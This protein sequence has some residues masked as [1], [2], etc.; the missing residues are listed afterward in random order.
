[1]FKKIVS[2]L[3]FSPALVGQLSFYAKRL[4]K[5]EISRRLGLIF[6]IFTLVIQ[7]LAVFQPPE[8]ANASSQYDM[9]QGG[10][11]SINDFLD[12][13]DN[14]T[15]NLQDIMEYVGITRKEITAATYTTFTV[16]S[17]IKYNWS[18]ASRVSYQD[19]ERQYIIPST[20]GTQT[21]TVYSRPLDLS[22]ASGTTLYAWIGSSA[23]MGKFAILQSCGNLETVKLPTIPAPT[24]KTTTTTTTTNDEEEE[25]ED[26]EEPKRCAVK[27]SL[28]ASDN[29]CTECPGDET[30]WIHDSACAP[31]II[32]SK[33]AKNI[34]QGYT[35]ATSTKAKAG[36]RISYTI[37]V[38]NDGLNSKTLPLKDDLSDILEYSELSDNGGGTLDN[39]TKTLSWSSITLDPGEKQTR[40]FV[41]KLLDPLP[42]SAKGVS[43]PTSYDCIM[44]NVFGNST[45]INVDCPIPKIVEE[46]T[47]QLP[48]TGPR[49]NVIFSCVILAVTTY[50]FMRSRQLGKEIRII[51]R[52]TCAGTL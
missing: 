18:L 47:S 5:E 1:M 2:N 28:L 50:F 20:S 34:T 29:D 45:N 14:N 52:D 38:K 13:Y 41:V 22:Y 19:G 12:A 16:G 46:V 42:A 33:D 9:V 11:S 6:V 8:S 17:D 7:S 25:E 44:T 36:D 26:E 23:S 35:D 40:T 3:P 31:N 48:T 51:R 21:V 27:P 32:K 43:D 24:K 37:T 39:S 49:E 15:R 10:I 30:I 4:S